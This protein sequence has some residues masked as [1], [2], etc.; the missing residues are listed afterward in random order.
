MD[1]IKNFNVRSINKDQTKEWLRYKHYAKRIPP[2]SYTFGLFNDTSEFKPYGFPN[3]FLHIF[4]LAFICL[5]ILIFI[6]TR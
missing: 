4:A 5:E 6:T 3:F 2:M 1:D